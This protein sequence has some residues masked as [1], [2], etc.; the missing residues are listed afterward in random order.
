M[1]NSVIYMRVSTE[2]Q[3]KKGYSLKYQEEMSGLIQEGRATQQQVNE[4]GMGMLMSEAAN[5][6]LQANQLSAQG[7]PNTL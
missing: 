5:K 4:Q 1:K 3:A 2:K 7:G 6:I